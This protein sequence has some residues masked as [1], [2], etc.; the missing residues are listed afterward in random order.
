[1][2]RLVK[3]IGWFLA[4]A[5]IALAVLPWWLSPVIKGVTR[6]Y[7]VDFARYERVGYARFA[8]HD[9]VIVTKS[10]VRVE[11]KRVETETP[12]LWLFHRWSGKPA[13]VAGTDWRVDVKTSDSP[14]SPAAPARDRGAMPLRAQLLKVASTL[15]RWLPRADTGEGVVTWPGGELRLGAVHWAK[16]SLAVEPLRFKTQAADVRVTFTA[17]DEI[18]LT[19]KAVDGGE[20]DAVLKSIG[21]EINGQ[22]RAWD[23]V[24]PVAARFAQSGWMPESAQIQA[25]GW[26][27]PAT[28]LKLGESYATVRGDGRIEW[29]EGRFATSAN[30]TGEVP[31]GKKAPPL[32]AK[33]HA[34]GDAEKITVDS[35]LIDIP[36]VSAKLNAPAVFDRK[37]RSVAGASEFALDVDLEKQPWIPKAKG[38]IAGR[39]RISP[40]SGMEKFPLVEGTFQAENLAV[41]D[42]SV[43]RF[44]ANAS[45]GWPRLQVKEAVLGF[46]EGGQLTL[47]GGWDFGTRELV[48]ASADG[49]VRPSVV[50]RWLPA[51]MTF[52]S[53]TIAAKA[54][55][56]I[57]TLQHEGTARV[58][59]F[60]MPKVHPLA[61]ELAW[62]GTGSAVEISDGHVTAGASQVSFAGKLDAKSAELA[63]LKLEQEGTERFALTKPATI[64]WSPK[65]EVG[66]FHV[67]GSDASVALAGSAGETGSVD[68]AIRNFPS[69]WLT[70][71]V[72]LRGPEWRIASLDLQG[73]WDRGPATFLFRED[74]IVSLSPERVASVTSVAQK[75]GDGIKLEWLRVS[76]GAIP[77]VN[78]S[79]KLPL[80][81]FPGEASKVRLAKEAPLV[82]QVVTSS[83]PAFWEK[84]REAT[85][86]EF[87]D[88]EVKLDVTGTWEQPQGVVSARAAR[89]SADPQRIKFAFPA[90][91]ALDVHA[92]ADG[93]GVVVDRFAVLVE[94]QSVTAN[95][96]LPLSVKQWPEFK[97]APVDYLRREATLRLEIPDAEVAAFA[98]YTGQYLAP[99]GR[100]HVD[101]ALEH[102]GEM[103]GSLRLKDA[104]TRP[105]GP[106]GVLQEVQAEALLNGR[107]IEIKNVTARSGGQP[108]SLNGQVEL[109][110]AGAPKF[111]LALKGENLPLVRQTGLL[112]R[113]DLDL[114]LITG[115]DDATT[116]SGAVRLRESMFLSDVRALIP[117]GG[118]GGPARRPPFFSIDTPP[119]DAWRLDIDVRGEEFMRLRSTVF[120]GVASARFHLGGTLG[121]PRAV[122]EA[123]VNSGQVLL[124]FASFRV[125][126]GTVRLTEADPYSLRIYLAGTSRRYGYDLRMDITGTAV[127]PVVAFSSSPPLDAKQVLLMVTAGELPRDEINYGASQ[128]A[129]RLGTYLGQSLINNFGGDNADADRLT[130]STGERVSRQGR[131]TYN[132]EYRL[133]ERLTA[134]GEYDEFD[135]YN[136]GLKWRLFRTEKEKEREST[137]RAAENKREADERS[138]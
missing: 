84:L 45:L 67:S 57:A 70:D 32:T 55:G 95:G 134:V 10:N 108:V 103:T 41:G 60:S 42:W 75:E 109:P 21:N 121:E 64:R 113:A 99:A 93:Q 31:T 8:L 73:S 25:E 76:E 77:I 97:K 62:R 58:A 83:N 16:R 1:M 51:G 125:E 26:T 65:L 49:V 68:V 100:L 85:G 105:L 28:K 37:E 19:A 107:R 112:L 104:A 7:G 87:R 18:H 114:K 123:V 46:A 56:P 111:N 94:G 13:A 24:A 78:A 27:V 22:L 69:K 136:A 36:G 17:N 135:A 30:A 89:V 9:F 81:L 122:G 119:L 20:W 54:Q 11:V 72:T 126:Q 91:E 71:F 48:A 133:N 74:L 90:V 129:A 132:I 40:A 4:G 43:A 63:A 124:P 110:L 138:R 50:A 5:L 6:R 86:L 98:R 66:S 53:V 137:A 15:D 82:L 120:V 12:V 79:G 131:E 88:P 59:T 38:R 33:I 23:Q 117:K 130:I 47:R 3:I 96:K 14:A 2:R 106:L 116:V 127:D 115:S 128:R 35:L 92:T 80:M 29:R 118:G 61:A 44:T 102:G 34:S 101:L 39:A 52:E